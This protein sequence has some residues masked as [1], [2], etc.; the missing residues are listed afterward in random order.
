MSNSDTSLIAQIGRTVGLWGDLKFHI[1]TDFPEQFTIGSSYKS[2][3]GTLTIKA[4]NPTR[5]IILFTGYEDID[6]AKKLTNT[7][8]FANEAETQDKCNLKDGEHFWFDVI[9]CKLYE[10]SQD[11]GKVVDIQRLGDTDYLYIETDEDIVSDGFAKSFL[12]PYINRYVISAD[13]KEQ[14]VYTKDTK[15]ILEMS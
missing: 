1:H 13:T 8:I 2:S 9:G 5:G 6:S 4:I 14:I 11:L 3:R 7:K 15:D 12:V 10:G